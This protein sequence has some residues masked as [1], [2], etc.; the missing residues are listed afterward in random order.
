MLLAAGFL[1]IQNVIVRIFFQGNAEIGGI[2]PADF[3][4]T[5]LFLQT[6]TFFMVIFLSL[7]AWRI[8][9]KVFGEIA[10][11][12]SRLRLPIISGTI[13]FI[14]VILLYLA[15]G[16]IPASIAITVFF[17]HPIA[18]MLLGWWQNQARPTLFRW[19]IIT[20]VM[21]GL[22]WVIPELQTNFSSQFTLG[23]S[24]AFGAGIGFAL[25]ATT[26]QSALRAFPSLSFSL[27]TFTV[28]F[29]LSSITVLF[30]PL[31]PAQIVW[32]P[33]LIWSFGSG[34]I[35]LGGLVFT[36]LGIGLVGAPTATLIGSIEPALTAILAWLILQ[37]TLESR[38]MIGIAIV[39]LSIAGLGLDKIIPHQPKKCH[40]KK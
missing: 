33:L 7:L 28:L 25:Y 21:I 5:V 20:G 38:Q 22:I 29:I 1:S 14:T 30:L 13:Y 11:A 34:A 17:I 2:L 35:T 39:T 8:Q 32:F 18:V 4:H 9:P 12:R 36:N 31:N 27:I 40:N 10:I 23:L 26:A 15:I 24:C 6:R 19:G 37:E 16:S 3:E